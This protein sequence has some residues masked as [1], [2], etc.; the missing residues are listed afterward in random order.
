MQVEKATLEK[1]EEINRI[2]EKNYGCKLDFSN[3]N[4]YINNK[5]NKV[6]I[7]NKKIDEN[8]AK[9]SNYIGIYFGK[10]KRNEKIHLSIEG[11][12]LV[13]KFAN[14]NIA[15]VDDENLK[16][17]LE[18][19]NCYAKELINCEINNFVLIKN[20]DDFYG[21]GILRKNNIIES[22]VPKSRRIIYK[23]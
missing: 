21:S 23:K 14:K 2:L 22:F 19:Q 8:L 5:K 4:I 18:G 13:G 11:S 7:T 15:I 16:K 3:Y 6:Y 1:I 9:I 20:E 12:Q 17:Y 10:L